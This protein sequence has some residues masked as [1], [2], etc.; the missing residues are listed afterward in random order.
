MDPKITTIMGLLITMGVTTIALK[1]IW[2]WLKG[3]RRGTDPLALATICPLDQAA[4]VA[5]IS[6]IKST[7]ED[8]KITL[9]DLDIKLDH[10][11]SV[12]ERNTKSYTE[13]IIALND[14]KNMIKNNTAAVKT[15]AEE[16]SKQTALLRSIKNN[17]GNNGR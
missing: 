11:V 4:T 17:G 10:G 6:G 3:S 12:A 1:I 2:D 7:V 5:N 9:H 15:Q 8:N 16:A 13:F 14:L